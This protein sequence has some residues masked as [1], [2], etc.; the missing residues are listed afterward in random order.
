MA[1][2]SQKISVVSNVWIRQMIFAKAGD[3]MKGH[4][5]LFD[6]HTLLAKGEFAV[7]VNDKTTVFKAPHIVIIKKGL[8]HKIVALE[9]DSL[10][11]CIHPIRDGEKV[12]DIMD[13]ADI[14]VGVQMTVSD[15]I[16]YPVIE[17]STPE[18]SITRQI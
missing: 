13:P 12:E 10:G 6:H 17:D 9:D 4:K 2:C 8:E 14:P 15:G 16:I 11:F 7:T 5:H 18:N 3:E 1:E